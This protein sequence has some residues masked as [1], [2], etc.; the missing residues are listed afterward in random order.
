[1]RPSSRGREL[2]FVPAALRERAS[3]NTGSL[4]RDLLGYLS[5]AGS[6]LCGVTGLICLGLAVGLRLKLRRMA[7]HPVTPIA[8]TGPSGKV[9]V[10]GTVVSVGDG[11]ISPLDG[12]RCEYRHV[13][14]S[15][16][17]STGRSTTSSRREILDVQ[18]DTP[19]WIRDESGV[20]ALH[21][22]SPR[23]LHVTDSGSI[24]IPSY[25]ALRGRARAFFEAHGR[26]DDWAREN[27]GERW[28]TWNLSVWETRIREGT[29]LQV[30]GKATTIEAP[31]ELAGGYRGLPHRV[32]CIEDG[33]E[34]MWIESVSRQESISNARI[35]LKTYLQVGAVTL[36]IAAGLLLAGMLLH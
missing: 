13:I 25:R 9:S 19:V 33:E 5:Y 32:P 36:C 15:A 22:E 31:P 30:I 26:G 3:A 29:T 16:H 20:A 11:H 21:I 8:H 7:S 23:G 35:D 34:P 14:A 24:S 27:L 18:S 12:V 17:W 28:T 10:Q 4:A 6:V 1:M 2:L